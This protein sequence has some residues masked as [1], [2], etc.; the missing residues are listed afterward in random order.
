M[1][2]R[3]N[4]HPLPGQARAIVGRDGELAVI[5]AFLDGTAPAALVLEGPAGIGKT[6]LWQAGI[7]GARE[8]GRKVL[9]SRPLESDAGISFAGL[10]DLFGEL[11]EEVANELPEPQERALATALLRERANSDPVEPGAVNAA[12]RGALRSAGREHPLMLAIDDLQWLDGPSAN[13]LRHAGRRLGGENVLIL[14]TRRSIPQGQRSADLG[15][16]P[17]DVERIAVGPLDVEQI[18]EVAGELGRHLPVPVL[19]RIADLSGGNPFYALEL[20]RASEGAADRLDALAKG[21]TLGPLAGDRIAALPEATLEALGLVA[22]HAHPTSSTVAAVLEDEKA[23][24]PAFGAGVLEEDEGLLRFTHPLLAAAAYAAL[25]PRQQREAHARLAAVATD[26]EEQA[27]HL[28][29]STSAPNEEV[30]ATLDAGAEAA[31]RRGAPAVAADL[32]ERAAALTPTEDPGATAKRR[33]RAAWLHIRAGDKRRGTEICAG[34][35]KELPP[36]A[37]RAEA[38]SILAIAGVDLPAAEAVACGRRAVEESGTDPELRVGCLLSLANVMITVNDWRGIGEVTREAV[39]LA[40]RAASADSLTAALGVAGGNEAFRS[41]GGG[42]E[43]LRE[44]VARAGERLIPTAYDCPSV[45]LGRTHLWCDELDEARDTLERMRLLASEAGDEYGTAGIG[46]HLVEVEVRAGNLARAREVAEEDLAV[47][48][49]GEPDQELGYAIY[50][51]ALVAAHEGDADLARELTARGLEMAAA[52]EDEAGP[53]EHRCVLGFLEMS[54]GNPDA[55]LAQIEHL[56]ELLERIGIGEP[57]VL[58]CHADAIEALIAVGR[59]DEAET[60]L[61]AWEELGRE[62]ER[63]RLLATAARARGLLAAGRGEREQAFAAFDEAL[64]HHASF[65]VP[66]ERGRTLHALGVARRRAGQRRAARAT[67]NEALDRFR[68][69]GAGLWADRAR[70]ELGRLGGRAPAGDELTPTERR[71]AELVAAGATNKEV[72]STLFVSVRTVESNLT[73]IYSKLGVRSRAELASRGVPPHD[74][75]SV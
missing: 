67:L 21:E 22:S 25:S 37:A 18:R 40:R 2:H 64:G 68:E 24:D 55:A 5:E 43:L 52:V 61:V 42:R 56:P 47:L 20:C 53:M 60:R 7:A 50:G 63:P 8:R 70:A 15:L 41:P 51:R 71:V 49:Q 27:R 6:T 46:V 31:E 66:I 13:A 54:L 1:P 29:V 26:P 30:A 28:A 10:R 12:V 45:H 39:D 17:E 69:I 11:F 34:L 19:R 72:A 59:T 14:A 48:E 58:I 4:P 32:L 3:G 57:G 75:S 74:E 23:L 36:G 16:A 65:P 44:A 62:T 9:V 33:V 73:R 35:V 38:L